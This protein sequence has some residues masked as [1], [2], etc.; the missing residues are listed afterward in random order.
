MGLFSCGPGE[1]W[2]SKQTFFLRG[3]RV[4]HHSGWGRHC[5]LCC[6]AITGWEIGGG[7]YNTLGPL[8]SIK[9]TGVVNCCFLMLGFSAAFSTNLIKNGTISKFSCYNNTLL[10]C[11]RCDIYGDI[12]KTKEKVQSVFTKSNDWTLNWT[13]KCHWCVL[14]VVSFLHT[15]KPYCFLTSDLNLAGASAALQTLSLS[16]PS[17]FSAETTFSVQLDL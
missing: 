8:H 11:P 4:L 5:H 17:P 13:K 7:G 14:V 9:R 15:G 2:N 1:W 6:V 12:L 3:R 16:F 10:T